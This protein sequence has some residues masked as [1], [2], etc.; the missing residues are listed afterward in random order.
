MTPPDIGVKLSYYLTIRNKGMYLKSGFI[1]EFPAKL[2][3]K[4]IDGFVGDPGR[5]TTLFFQHSGGA[6]GRV[7]TDATAFAHRKAQANMYVTVAWPLENDATPHVDYIRKYWKDLEPYT[8][9]WYTND[10]SDQ[11]SRV[12]NANYQ[13]NFERLLKVKNQ[14]D[15]ENLFRLNANIKPT[16]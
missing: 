7:P 13:G 3:D 8:D 11:T 16:A 5:K 6:I 12:L 4:L 15:P 1:N 14:Y 10:A 9:G 2:V